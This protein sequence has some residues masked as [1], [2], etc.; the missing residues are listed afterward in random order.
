MGA[1]ATALIHMEAVFD[2]RNQVIPIGSMRQT[3]VLAHKVRGECHSRHLRLPFLNPFQETVF[4]DLSKSSP[5]WSRLLAARS[6]CSLV[7]PYSSAAQSSVTATGCSL[8][9]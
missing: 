3:P 5:A 7:S 6:N 4:P 1:P 9:I 2:P 8:T